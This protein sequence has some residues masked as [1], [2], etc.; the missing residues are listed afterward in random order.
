LLTVVAFFS[1]P[2]AGVPAFVGLTFKISFET[3]RHI[4][5]FWTHVP[6]SADLGVGQKNW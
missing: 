6:S 4:L 5:A 2:I 1:V 3:S